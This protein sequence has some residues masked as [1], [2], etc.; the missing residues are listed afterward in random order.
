MLKKTI[1]FMIMVVITAGVAYGKEYKAARKAGDHNVSITIDRNPPVVGKNNIEIAITDISDKAVTDAKV[2]IELSMPAMPGM[3][4]HSYKYN[5]D[6]K[7]QVYKAVI[8][9][10][11]AGS[12]NLSVRITRSGKTDTARATFDVQ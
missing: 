9:P 10:S 8:Q 11:M 3:P 1:V 6:L 12:W 7:G 2:A 5:A 4:A